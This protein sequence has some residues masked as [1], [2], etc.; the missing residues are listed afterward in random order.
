FDAINCMDWLEKYHAIIVC[1]EKIV[2]ISWGNEILIVHGDESDR[3]NET[4]L[5]I[6]SCSKMQKVGHLARDCRSAINANTA[7]N[8][9]GT[10]VGQ[11]PTCF[12]CEGQGHFKRGCQKLKDN[13]R[14]NPAGNGNAL[15][16]VTSTLLI[17]PVQNER[18]VRPTEGAIRQRLYKAQFLTLGSSD[19]VCQEERWII[20]NVHRLLRTEQANDEESLSTP[21]TPPF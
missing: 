15:V 12:E 8:Q 14:G 19:H 17:G 9:R 10:R 16:K 20:L 6:I 7:N 21:I 3:G 5:N 2:R 1:V 4:R 18:I 11:K 13:N